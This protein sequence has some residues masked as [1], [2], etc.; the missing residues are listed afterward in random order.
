MRAAGGMDIVFA[1]GFGNFIDSVG[2]LLKDFADRRLYHHLT[3]IRSQCRT[4][5]LWVASYYAE[6]RNKSSDEQTKNVH[7]E[8]L[9]FS[10]FPSGSLYMYEYL[11]KIVSYTSAVGIT[12]STMHYAELAVMPR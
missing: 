6:R 9:D 4:Y 1:D 7:R 11:T 3:E 2:R 8:Y 5:V 12:H 10:V